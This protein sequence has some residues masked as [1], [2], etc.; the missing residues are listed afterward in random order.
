MR[1]GH[2]SGGFAA[3]AGSR[4]GKPGNPAAR[5]VHAGNEHVFGQFIALV[6]VDS[7]IDREAVVAFF[8]QQ[9][10]AGVG[11]VDAEGCAVAPVHE[12][13][14][15]G[16]ILGPVQTLAVNIGKKV[17]AFSNFVVEIF[18][19][20]AVENLGTVGDVGRAG[21]FQRGVGYRR[22]DRA[23]HVETHQHDHA[24]HDAG[25]FVADIFQGCVPQHFIG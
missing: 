21:D 24:P 2:G 22:A 5:A 8:Q 3:A 11:A 13:P 12:H 20:I 6:F 17:P 1:A 25:H 10:I 18:E 9:G 19:R 16:Q 4:A 15:V 23:A 7:L 14:G